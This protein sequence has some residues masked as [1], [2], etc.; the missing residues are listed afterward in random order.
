MNEEIYIKNHYQIILI[1]KFLHQNSG[2]LFYRNMKF[3]SCQ[4]NIFNISIFNI[5]IFENYNQYNKN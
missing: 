1:L 5:Y 4:N 2:F 3:E